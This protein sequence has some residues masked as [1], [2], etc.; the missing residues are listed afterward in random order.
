MIEVLTGKRETVIYEENIP[1]RM[2][3]NTDA[4]NFPLHWQYSYEIIMPLARGYTLSLENCTEELAPGDIIII[5][6]GVL[7]SIVAPTSGAR[8]ILLVN[9]SI[10]E[11]IAD[12]RNLRDY[13]HPYVIFTQD[14]NSSRRKL[15]QQLLNGIWHEYS[16]KNP[17]KY[18]SLHSSILSFFV[19]A[20]RNKSAPHHHLLS[21]EDLLSPAVQ[22]HTDKFRN[23]CTFI[24]EHCMEN[25][26]IEKLA[27]ISG[28][29]TSHFYRLLKQYTGLSY[30]KYLNQ[31]RIAHAKHLLCQHM[32]MTVLDVSLHCG[33]A[34]LSTFN[35]SFKA[36]TKLTPSE[37]RN[38]NPQEK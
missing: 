16:S 8:Y 1:I 7:H 34:S 14:A 18:V 12:A 28:F 36:I 11:N 20:H 24:S 35:R 23:I 19:A 26:S 13:F 6:P 33:F 22:K 25:I 15:L 10:F 9:P 30:H 31:I 29:S 4:E 21:G 17:L 2:H 3:L 32:G 27:A 38:L 5:A 37:Y